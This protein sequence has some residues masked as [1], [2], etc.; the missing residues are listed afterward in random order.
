[1]EKNEKLSV[2]PESGDVQADAAMSTENVELKAV[3]SGKA[4]PLDD[5]PDEVFSQHVMG[6]GLAIEPSDNTVV[7]PADAEV[8]VVMEDTG[9]A[10]G[11]ALAKGM[12]LLIHVGVDTVDMGGDGFELLVKSG[13]KVRAGDPLIRFDPEK[14]RA[15]GHPTTT[16]II[17]TEEGEAGERHRCLR[18][19]LSYNS[20]K[21]TGSWLK[22]N[23]RKSIV[24]PQEGHFR[25]S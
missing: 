14:I 6:D 15:A 9:H 1:M 19:T 7:A 25:G 13:G 2:K 22:Y 24:V 21:G 11:L 8:S 5:V 16:V 12:E 4:I 3:L 18:I 20:C 23:S 17:V 10:C